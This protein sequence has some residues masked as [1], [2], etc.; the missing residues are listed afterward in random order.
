[1]C[2]MGNNI[3]QCPIYGATIFERA[4]TSSNVNRRRSFLYST[5]SAERSSA[6][7]ADAPADAADVDA[8]AAAAA[9]DDDV[10]DVDDGGALTPA[11]SE[12]A[13]P[14]AAES[15]ELS[16]LTVVLSIWQS[17]EAPPFCACCSWC[18]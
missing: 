10:L 17:A 15:S 7:D 9:A 13:E 14:R 3:N 1:M 16:S 18:V 5:S 12:P 11:Y 2:K 8:A 6:G 4:R